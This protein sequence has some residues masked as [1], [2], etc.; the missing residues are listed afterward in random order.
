MG[1]DFAYMGTRF[2][3]TQ[4]A[5]A[6]P[7]YKEALVQAEAADIV[8]TPYFTG[9]AG[10]YLKSSIVAAGLDPDNLP[11]RDKSA[12]DFAAVEAAGPKAWRDIWGAG[13][14][15]SGIQDVPSVAELVKRLKEE[16]FSATMLGFTRPS[17]SVGRAED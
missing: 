9:I 10:N 12:M 14:S 13:Q 15:V 16:Y 3:A 1:A 8:N 4:E 17:S 6:G 11:L 5:H 7:D 2:L